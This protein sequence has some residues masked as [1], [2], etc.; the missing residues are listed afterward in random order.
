MAPPSSKGPTLEAVELQLCPYSINHQALSQKSLSNPN[1][2]SLSLLPLRS[3]HLLLPT[4]AT[5]NLS[6]TLL[7]RA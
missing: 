5:I 4:L 2:T 3:H 7:T 1:P 6:T